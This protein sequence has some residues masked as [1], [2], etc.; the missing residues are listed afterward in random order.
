M[1]VQAPGAEQARVMLDTMMGEIAAE[2][3]M[4]DAR[5]LP[6]LPQ[7]A[8]NRL[9]ESYARHGDPRRLR[10]ELTRLLAIAARAE[11][12]WTTCPASNLH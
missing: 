9:G 10:A 6:T 8:L 3:G 1:V 2:R 5:M 12:L 11:E 4:R 7:P